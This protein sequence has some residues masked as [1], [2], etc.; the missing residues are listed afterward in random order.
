M[1]GAV[2]RVERAK[3][4]SYREVA[5]WA[6]EDYFEDPDDEARWR[7]ALTAWLEEVD[8]RKMTLPTRYRGDFDQRLDDLARV[9]LL[10]ERAAKVL[11]KPQV[12]KVAHEAAGAVRYGVAPGLVPLMALHFAQLGRARCRALYERGIRNVEALAAAD[13]RSVADPR[14]DGRQRVSE[15]VGKMGAGKPGGQFNSFIGRVRL[16]CRFAAQ[17]APACLR[18]VR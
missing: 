17:G 10:Y 16:A 11:G 14:R 5:S 1:R 7:R 18:S 6:V 13:P 12:A 15:L 8:V 3:S 2:E 4:A 9:C